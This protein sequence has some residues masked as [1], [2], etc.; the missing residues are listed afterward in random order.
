[1]S[2]QNIYKVLVYYSA[3]KAFN[4]LRITH[5]PE[6]LWIIPA[7]WK[8]VMQ[9]PLSWVDL[10]DEASGS[11]TRSVNIIATY[12]CH[13][14]PHITV[15]A[16][17]CPLQTLVPALMCQ[18][19]KVHPVISESTLDDLQTILQELADP[20]ACLTPSKSTQILVQA[21]RQRRKSQLPQTAYAER[22]LIPLL[23]DSA[24][25][26]DSQNAK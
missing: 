9:D 7:V 5:R 18:S 4:E 11:F 17:T 3:L 14:D 10:S 2:Y 15:D 26:S 16:Y 12:V 23:P 6:E 20:T 1:M 8:S 24:V 13:N 22:T 21:L 25:G 19:T